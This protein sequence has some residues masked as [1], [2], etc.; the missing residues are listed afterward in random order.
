MASKT[1][2]L[3]LTTKVDL[4]Q[5]IEDAGLTGTVSVAPVTMPSGK[6]ILQVSS[7]AD[8]EKLRTLVHSV[9]QKVP[10]KAATEN[11]EALAGLFYER[12]RKRIPEND[13]PFPALPL[14]TYESEG[15]PR[16]LSQETVMTDAWNPILYG[17][18][19]DFAPTSRINP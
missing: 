5:A 10:E 3:V 19:L 14:L 17:T 6:H 8:P 4:K 15:S 12:A 1:S 11:A 7:S 18:K 13:T 2:S 16:L 9:S